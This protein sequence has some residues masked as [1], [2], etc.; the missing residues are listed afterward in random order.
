[1]E[2]ISFHVTEFQ[3]ILD[4]MQIQVDNVTCLV[5][6]NESGKT[7]LLQALYRLNPIREADKHYSVTDDYPR[8]EV[9]D[10][11]EAIR[12]KQRSSATVIKA[13]FALI[14]NEI[15]SVT[16]KLGGNC[17]NTT[18][19][20]ITKNYEDSITAVVNVNEQAAKEFVCRTLSPQ[21]QNQ[22]GTAPYAFASGEINML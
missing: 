7:A 21:L 10:Y 12:L 16:E 19:V 22:I 15:S 11:E 6:K 14:D 4:S 5:G 17:F 3:S 9:T 8:M 1:M 20:V 18:N 13:E 2:L